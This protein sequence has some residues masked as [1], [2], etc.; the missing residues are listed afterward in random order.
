MLALCCRFIKNANLTSLRGQPMES[1]VLCVTGAAP[2]L[3]SKSV[4]DVWGRW[5]A[6]GSLCVHSRRRPFGRCLS[7]GQWECHQVD[8]KPVRSCHLHTP[9]LPECATKGLALPLDTTDP[10]SAQRSTPSDPDPTR[11]SPRCPPGTLRKPVQSLS[12][13]PLLRGDPAQKSSQ[14]PGPSE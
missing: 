8:W 10:Y 3:D 11:L 7:T 4:Q 12:P 13:S 14:E 1:G 5:M 9:N 2:W 6:V